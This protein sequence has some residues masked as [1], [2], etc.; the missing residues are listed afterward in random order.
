[1]P[2]QGIWGPSPVQPGKGQQHPFAYQPYPPACATKGT[3]W[4]GAHHQRGSDA[5]TTRPYH[6]G[7]PDPLTAVASERGADLGGGVGIMSDGSQGF[8]S[9][10][11]ASLGKGGANHQ[12]GGG[13]CGLIQ[14]LSNGPMLGLTAP[15][16]NAAD[17][18]AA[19]ILLRAGLPAQGAG[20]VM[21]Q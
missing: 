1:M 4:L 19:A 5:A 18:M 16:S 9:S 6:G 12:C 14:G 10:H 15:A 2:A 17:G 20:G 11:G 13:G 3:T 7:L 21:P 8:P